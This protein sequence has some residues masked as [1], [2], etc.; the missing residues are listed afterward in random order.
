MSSIMTGK[1]QQ[2][3][4]PFLLLVSLC[5]FNSRAPMERPICVMAMICITVLFFS[6]IAVLACVA[7]EFKRTKVEDVKLDSKLCRLPG[8][9]SFGLGIVASICLLVTQ[10][11][12]SS[13][14]SCQFCSRQKEFGIHAKRKTTAIAFFLLSWITFGF[15]VLLAGVGASM[16]KRQ[17]YGDGWLNGEC[18]VVR[19]GVFIGSAALGVTFERYVEIGGVVVDAIDQNRA[20]L[21][22]ATEDEAFMS[23][24]R[25]MDA[26]SILNERCI[27][28]ND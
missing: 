20:L 11:I 13:A 27:V 23:F 14:F 8:S 5:K 7:A 19:K 25:N 1:S 2:P 18:Y 10:I 4:G 26:R 28:E 15:A 3:Q 24:D 17:Y 6:L 21:F 22:V 12:G 16:N 9:P